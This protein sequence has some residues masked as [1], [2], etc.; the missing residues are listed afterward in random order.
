MSVKPEIFYSPLLDE[1]EESFNTSFNQAW[2]HALAE[3]SHIDEG[4][5]RQVEDFFI[6]K[7]SFESDSGKIL[8]IVVIIEDIVSLVR[9]FMLPRLRDKLRVSGFYRG[10]DSL[11]PDLRIKYRFIAYAFPHNI[12]RLAE[13]A[14]RI[15]SAL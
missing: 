2:F 11:A 4:L 9:R 1:L 8:E 12:R 13:I 3:N 15:K 10:N 5:I 7:D 6:M 14:E